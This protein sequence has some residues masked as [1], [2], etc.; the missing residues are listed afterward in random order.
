MIMNLKKLMQFKF[1]LHQV[2]GDIKERRQREP[3]THLD[4]RFP[5]SKILELERG[6]MDPF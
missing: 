2:I 5:K 4:Q 1:H 3:S 6:K